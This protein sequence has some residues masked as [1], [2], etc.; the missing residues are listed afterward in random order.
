MT[1]GGGERRCEEEFSQMVTVAAFERGWEKQTRKETV[2][3][4][5]RTGERLPGAPVFRY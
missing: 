2:S 1:H 3:E 5:E 4:Q